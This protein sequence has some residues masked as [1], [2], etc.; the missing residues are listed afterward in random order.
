MVRISPIIMSLFLAGGAY[1]APATEKSTKDIYLDVYGPFDTW[2][3]ALSGFRLYW[4]VL[5]IGHTL[6]SFISLK[7]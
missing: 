4:Q 7:N 3:C 5:Y 1:S 2:V 6:H